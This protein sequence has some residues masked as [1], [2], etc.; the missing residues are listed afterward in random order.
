M[1]R[2]DAKLEEFALR[3][4]ELLEESTE[5]LDGRVRSRLTQARSAAIEE[6]RRSR[7]GFAWRAWIP[8]GA[9]AGAAALA[10]FLWSGAPQSPE[11]SPIAVHGS[12]DDLDIIVTDESFELLEDLEF[13]EWIAVDE[14]NGA[15]IG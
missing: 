14:A 7:H 6:A 8:A 1:S 13:Y 2:D 15:S 9:L 5:R 11:T 10:V 3:S 4:R 12:L